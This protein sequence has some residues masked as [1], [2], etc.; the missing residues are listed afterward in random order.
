M[1]MDYRAMQDPEFLMIVVGVLGHILLEKGITTEEEIGELVKE[2][3]YEVFS[4]KYADE[5]AENS[6]EIP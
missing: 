5:K 3:S 6:E 4:E 1:K 2:A